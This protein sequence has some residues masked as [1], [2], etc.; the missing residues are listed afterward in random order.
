MGAQPRGE[1]G[2]SWWTLPPTPIPHE[3]C[4]PA[5]IPP[6]GRWIS[7]VDT[8]PPPP[9]CPRGAG[10][11]TLSPHPAPR[12][13][14][15]AWTLPPHPVPA[16][17]WTSARLVPG[18]RAA[19]SQYLMTAMLT[20]AVQVTATSGFSEAMARKELPPQAAARRPGSHLFRPRLALRDSLFA[21]RPIGG[22]PGLRSTA[23]PMRGIERWTADSGPAPVE[24]TPRARSAQARE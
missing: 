9:S 15:P 6:P 3:H 4:P 12:G 20:G 21:R 5:L 17:G 1:G 13:G 8:V 22:G 23:Q 14:H 24:R 11:W 19:H 18:T 10:R 7:R 16:R 2:A